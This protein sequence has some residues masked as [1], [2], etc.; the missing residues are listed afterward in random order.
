MKFAFSGSC[1]V[2]TEI[3]LIHLIL[4]SFMVRELIQRAKTPLKFACSALP[5]CL[6]L[7]NSKFQEEIYPKTSL[8]EL[9]LLI[10]K[11]YYAFKG[12]KLF[13]EK[14][15]TNVVFHDHVLI[16]L[17]ISKLTGPIRGATSAEWF[18]SKNSPSASEHQYQNNGS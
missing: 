6:F 18:I 16:Q 14:W 9:P 2:R 15:L 12:V 10:I 8:R 3:L 5:T 13:Y 1:W 11:P 4:G 7:M 17:G